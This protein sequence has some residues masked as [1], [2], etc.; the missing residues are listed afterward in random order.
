VAGLVGSKV[1]YIITV[2]PDIINDP[3]LLIKEFNSGFVIYGGVIFGVLTG[4]WYARNRKWSFM[5]VFDIA[6]PLLAMAQGF[7]RIGCLFAGCCFGKET[8]SFLGIQFVHSPFAPNHVSLIPTQVISSL[9]DFAIAGVLMWFDLRRKKKDGHTGALYLILYSIGRFIIEIFRDDPRGSVFNIFSTSQFIC[10]FV[11]IAGIILFYYVSRKYRLVSEGAAASE[12]EA[13]IMQNENKE[14]EIQETG[15][16]L[17]EASP[18]DNC[19][20]DDEQ[21]TK[22]K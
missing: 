3:S 7:G 4:W 5:K 14:E 11:F 8:D 9:G 6:A 1:F 13:E 21:D 10:I 15:S 16:S 19:T 22:D 17:D 12:T 20:K 2:L 18:A